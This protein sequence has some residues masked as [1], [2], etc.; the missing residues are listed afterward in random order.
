MYFHHLFF[1]VVDFF[2][3]VLFTVKRFCDFGQEEAFCSV[4]VKKKRWT[5]ILFRRSST[6]K[7]QNF[8]NLLVNKSLLVI[9][10]KV[11]YRT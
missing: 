1:N 6:T 2:S 3:N 4:I 5:P 7:I 11:I 8:V 10:E 9:T